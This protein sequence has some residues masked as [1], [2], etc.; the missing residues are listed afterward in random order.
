MRL[1]E[2][3]CGCIGFGSRMDGEDHILVS[4]CDDDTGELCIVERDM[5]KKTIVKHL[6]K[7]DAYSIQMEIRD[8]IIDGYK[9]RKIQDLLT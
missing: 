9:F 3:D 8:L 6:S 4:C 1:F 5:R 2:Y 7:S